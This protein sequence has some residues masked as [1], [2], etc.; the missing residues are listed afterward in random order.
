MTMGHQDQIHQ[1]L[2][3]H[4]VVLFVKGSRH[5][6]RCGF[7]ASVIQIFEEIGEPF[8][9][10]DVLADPAL[11]PALCAVTDWPTLPQI[12]VGGRFVG[13]GDLVRELHARGELAGLV[14]A[15]PAV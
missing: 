10:V 13:G 11:R 4:H 14:R 6:P 9:C 8:E 5:F 15:R 2:R 7:S 12:F 3:E 1:A